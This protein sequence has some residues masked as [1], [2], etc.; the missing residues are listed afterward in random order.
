MKK[1]TVGG[2]GSRDNRESHAG[3]GKRTQ[4]ANRMEV[5]SGIKVI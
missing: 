4:N 2:D 5:K 3:V 1:T